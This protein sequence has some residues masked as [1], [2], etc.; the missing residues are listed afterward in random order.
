MIYW[1]KPR[2]WV[3][4]LFNVTINDISVI[5]VTAQVTYMCRQT[6]EEF[7]PTWLPHHRHFVGFFNICP[8]TNKGPTFL[9]LFRETVPFQLPF[10][11]RMGIQRFYSCRKPQSP[12]EKMMI[13]WYNWQI[14]QRPV[15]SKFDRQSDIFWWMSDKKCW[16]AWPNV[17]QTIKKKLVNEHDEKKWNTNDHDKGQ[18]IGFISSC[19]FWRPW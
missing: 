16:S 17:R 6:E 12:I 14:S 10:T 11:K 13:K 1:F 19:C 5:N 4:W 7:G 15:L 2:E 18:Q 8:S 9:R 3:N